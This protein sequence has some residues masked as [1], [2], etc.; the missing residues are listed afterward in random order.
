MA[1]LQHNGHSDIALHLDDTVNRMEQ[2]GKAGAEVEAVRR[3]VQEASMLAR[4][5]KRAKG[6][7]MGS[8]RAVAEE[9]GQLASTL[10]AELSDLRNSMRSTQALPCSRAHV[11]CHDSSGCR[12]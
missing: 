12:N 9:R 6:G 2:A 5:E 8:M 4:R 10:R 7:E 11:A 3:S 1:K